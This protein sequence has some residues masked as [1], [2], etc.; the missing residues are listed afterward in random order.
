M[1]T[2]N[3]LFA[4]ALLATAAMARAD[5]PMHDPQLDAI[6]A[7]L[8]EAK[9]KLHRCWEKAA[10]DDFHL[11]GKIVLKVTFGA[12]GKAAKVDVVSDE[13]KDPVLTAC[14]VDLAKDWSW[15]PAFRAGDGVQVPLTF[16]A[17]A[18]QYTVRTEDAPVR[19]PK[20]G[21]LEARI[22]VDR[23]SVGADKASL[24]VLDL[25]L[26]TAIPMHRVTS[27]KIIY[28]LDGS[29]HVR[30]LGKS[31]GNG[32]GVDLGAG[33][34]IYVPAGVPSAIEATCCKKAPARLLVLYAPGGPEQ[35]FKDPKAPE[36]SATTAVTG[37]EAKKAPADAPAPKTAK[38]NEAKELTIGGGKGHVKI[39][40]DKD[41]A[42]DGAAYVGLLRFDGGAAVPEHAHAAEAEILYVVDGSG[43][44]TVNGE[45]VPVEAGMAVYIP[46]GAKHQFK[47]DK[48]VTAVQFYTPSGPEQRFKQAPK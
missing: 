17:P 39:L 47:T 24:T 22:L 7:G 13:A 30:G 19:A 38:A 20:G 29:V 43:D 4:L 33:D 32:T 48:G 3:K 11:Q 12:G 45:A 31:L 1:R 15:G 46:P 9:P 8:E 16:A 44:M 40:F 36:R 14:V 27:A 5:E 10:A 34:A 28:V 25:K 23:A 42:G 35:P 41:A 26:G 37:D 21:K 18:A 6:A 2:T